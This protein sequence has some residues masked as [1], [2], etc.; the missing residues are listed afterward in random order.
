[1]RG[2]RSSRDSFFLIYSSALLVLVLLGFAPTFFFR[3][4]IQDPLPITGSLVLHGVVLT[5]W[6]LLFVVQAG[7]I[8]QEN[9]SL[10]RTVGYVSVGYGV[11][12]VAGALLAPV[13]RVGR[14]QDLGATLDMDIARVMALDSGLGAEE[15][16]TVT[17]FGVSAIEAMSG[18]MWGFVVSLTGFAVLFGA[19][20][21]FRR[22]VDVHKRLMALASLLILPPALARIARW[23]FLGG[24]NGPFGPI[25]VATLVATLIMYDVSTRGKPHVATVVGGIVVFA[26]WLVPISD[27][28]FWQPLFR[29]FA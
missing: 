27:T 6:F 13:A 20:V 24:E 8:R 12:V 19:A 17:P 28:E 11:V 5:G 23:P 18:Q 15:A 3:F 16:G 9:R 21:L 26:E 10:H 29:W 2:E 14:L 22:R 7:L 25:A 1:M 4:L